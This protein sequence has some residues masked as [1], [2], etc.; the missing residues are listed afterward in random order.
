MQAA[1]VH[2]RVA[3]GCLHQALPVLVL[4]PHVSR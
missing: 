3:H 1:H 2:S 4:I